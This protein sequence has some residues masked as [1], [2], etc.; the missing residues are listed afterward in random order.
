MDDRYAK[1]MERAERVLQN[2]SS[3]T[4]EARAATQRTRRRR[5]RD[6]GRR[7]MRIVG[8]VA[9]IFAV[10]IV[11]G[12]IAPVGTAGLMAAVVL[13]ILAAAMLMVFPKSRQ[14][15][16]A[17]EALSN[18]E[19]VHRLD[20]LLIR[21]RPALPAPALA[22]VDAISARL[23]LLE[24]RLETLDALDPLA[25]DA[26]RLMGQHLPDLLGRY[27][28]VPAEYRKQQDGGGMSVEDRL[29]SGLGAA[30]S[31]IDDLG[32]K[33][34]KADLNAFETHGRFIESRYNDGEIGPC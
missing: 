12:F 15:V 13:A 16:A 10:M 2:L 23:P 8:A 28:K 6:A 34:A 26:R 3:R 11:W 21:E 5:N 19:I 7:A 14:D 24:K 20:S 17:V 22:E 1:S 33:L 9:A 32:E 30:R 29:L 31:A 18:T 27:E 25:Q 4:P